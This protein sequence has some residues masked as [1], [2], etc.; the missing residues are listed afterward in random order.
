MIEPEISSPSSPDSST[1]GAKTK[2]A[3]SLKD[4]YEAALTLDQ[5]IAGARENRK[6]WADMAA[7]ARTPMDVAAWAQQLTSDWRLLV[8]L[9]DWCGD[10]VNTIPVLGALAAAV[11]RL[12][13]RVLKRDENLDLMGAHLTDGA[14]AIPMVL[15][16]DENYVERGWWGPRPVELQRWATSAD[17]R[18]MA[19]HDRYREARRW[20]A[21]DRGRTTLTEVLSLI[22]RTTQLIPRA[23]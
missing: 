9:E 4:R 20:Y 19:L 2:Q 16:L 13:L 5:F 15:V 18:A 14:S 3:A 12:D 10:A 1:D 21:R 7:R 11:P 22:E 17:A 8:L 6:L 23:A